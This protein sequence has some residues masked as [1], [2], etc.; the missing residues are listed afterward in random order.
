M[1]NVHPA[2]LIDFK[3]L[4]INPWI[5]LIRSTRAHFL[6]S[7][8]SDHT[9]SQRQ[10]H[11]YHRDC[12]GAQI[13]VLSMKLSEWIQSDPVVRGVD[14]PALCEAF[15][16]LGYMAGST[17]SEQDREVDDSDEWKEKNPGVD[18]RARPQKGNT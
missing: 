18:L 15:D 8:I 1:Q 17:E 14:L 9:K 12:A 11:R 4:D 5:R 2:R 3:C 10:T 7:A 13:S 6:N 16:L